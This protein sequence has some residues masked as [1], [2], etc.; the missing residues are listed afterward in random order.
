MNQMSN[1]PNANDRS[2]DDPFTQADPYKT[3]QSYEPVT[4]GTAPGMR[5][6]G[7]NIICI[8][9]IALGVLVA[10]SSGS[11]LVMLPFQKAIQGMVMPP[12]VVAP[13]GQKLSPQDEMQSIQRDMQVKLV[14]VT[15]KYFW[16]LLVLHLFQFGVAIWLVAS[17]VG[18]L[19][20]SSAS[21][22]QFTL[23]LT[24]MIAMEVFFA[25]PAIM[26]QMESI[27]ILNTMLERLGNSDQ[28]AQMM[29]SVMK[30]IVFASFIL[31][32]CM[33]VVRIGFYLYAISYLRRSAIVAL[34]NK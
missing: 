17:A 24:G 4:T 33:V 27:Q 3:P 9:S 12:P 21:R 31:T 16:F 7:L 14:E 19:S 2:A 26:I 30:G 6:I 15:G 13:P 20:L 29:K 5:P 11:S 25:I 32:G 22:G 10:L 34:C 1:D 8:V 23:A 28:Q 18:T